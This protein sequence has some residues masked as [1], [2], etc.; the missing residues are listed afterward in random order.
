MFGYVEKR[1]RKDTIVNFNIYSA[2]GWTTNNY[3]THIPNISRNNNNQSTKFGQLIEYI[4][5][6][7]FFLRIMQKMKD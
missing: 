6:V 3:D 2:T 1:L 4:V 5:R 7:I